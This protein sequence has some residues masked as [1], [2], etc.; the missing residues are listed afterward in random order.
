MIRLNKKH[1]ILVLIVVLVVS[2]GYY[3]TKKMSNNNVLEFF[4]SQE[5]GA[6]VYEHAG[7]KGWNIKF[8]VGAFGCGDIKVMGGKN[9]QISSI[10]VLPGYNAILYQHCAFGGYKVRFQPGEYD[11]PAF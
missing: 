10:K 2:L 1:L 11:Y 3:F 4:Q 8:P 5:I 6:I 7:F 9:D